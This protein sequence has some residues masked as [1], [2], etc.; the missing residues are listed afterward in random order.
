MTEPEEERMYVVVQHEIRDA[1]AAFARGQALMEGRGAPAGARVL[2][3][4]PGRDRATVT[5][6]WEADSVGA[7][8]RYVDD[9]LGGSSVNACYE[10]DA[11]AAFARRPL[12]IPESATVA[13][14]AAPPS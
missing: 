5:C 6:L 12:G 14:P 4:Y 3:F 9:T 8:Q 10:V 11:E 2:Q 1:E 7:V 13:A